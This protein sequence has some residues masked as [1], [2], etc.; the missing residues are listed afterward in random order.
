MHSFEIMAFNIE[1]SI[2]FRF[3]LYLVLQYENTVDT[4]Q[5]SFSTVFALLC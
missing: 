1:Q 5:Y 3:I 4:E 2:L